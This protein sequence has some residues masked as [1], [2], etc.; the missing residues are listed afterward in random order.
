MIFCVQV[1]ARI[2]PDNADK[3]EWIVVK[4]IRFDR[5]SNKC[6]ILNAIALEFAYSSKFQICLLDFLPFLH[7]ILLKFCRFEVIDEEPGDEDESI[8]RFHVTSLFLYL[9]AC[10]SL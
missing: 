8:Q 7:L 3:D 1:A 4:V 9:P 5:E 2:S 10:V 6:D